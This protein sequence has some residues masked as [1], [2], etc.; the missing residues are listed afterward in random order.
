MKRNCLAVMIIALMVAAS[1][2]AAATPYNTVTVDGLW[3]AGEW[4]Q[5]NETVASNTFGG[6]GDYGNVQSVLVTWDAS[7][8]YVGLRG[9]AWNNAMLLYIDSSSIATGQ[10]N[11]DYFQGF[12]TQGFFDADFVA[13][14]YNMEWGSG[15]VP[16]DI[17]AISSV[18]GITT[19]LI[20]PASVAVHDKNGDG[21]LGEGLLEVAIP[22]SLIGLEVG[23]SVRVAA[24]VGWAINQNPVIPAGGLGGFSGDELGGT[25]QQGGTDALDSTLDGAV[26]VVYDADADGLPDQLTDALAPSLLSAAAL[27]GDNSLLAATFDEPVTQASAENLANWA[28][29]GGLSVTGATLQADPAV[30]HLQLDASAGFGQSYAVTATGIED[31]NSNVSGATSANF[32]LA[33]LTFIAHMKYKIEAAGAPAAVSLEG[34]MAPLTWDPTCDDPLY[35]DGTHGDVAAG[36]STYA[37]QLVFCLSY[38]EGETPPT[39]Q[40]A[41]KLTFGCTDWESISDRTFDLSCATGQD[42]VAFYWNNENPED[43]TTAPVDVI[44]TVDVSDS[45]GRALVGINGGQGNGSAVPPLNWNLPSENALSDDGYPG[46][47]LDD[48][49][50]GTILRFPEQSFRNVEYKFVYNDVYECQD[51]G[52]RGVWLNEAAFDTLGGVLGPLVMPTSRLQRCTVTARAVEV[53]FAVDMSY[54][55]EG[56]LPGDTLAVNGST[57][58]LN[59]DIPSLAAMADDGLYPDNAAGD[60]IFSRSVVFPDSSN[61]TVDY[62]YLWNSA[63]ECTTQGNRYF[64][65][66]D[67]LFDDTGNP[68]VLDV[69]IFNV[70]DA[71]AAEDTPLAAAGVVLRGNYPNP[72]NPKTDIVFTLAAPGRVRLEIFDLSGRLVRTL[73]DAEAPAGDHIARWAGRDDRGQAVSSGIYFARISAHGRFESRKMTLLK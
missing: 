42:T 55:A 54:L 69:D 15:T 72:F 20:G 30:V 33:E 16:T 14:C 50:Y 21:G 11:A 70:C 51:Q 32:C 5:A 31:L 62:K 61:F 67:T 22:W 53:V 56:P 49:I 25:D 29:D 19:S 45:L 6:W 43:F 60:L 47:V 26:T 27:E 1:L 38:G 28:I 64:W 39:V 52:N 48:G 18:D 2:P 34:S 63:Y 13:G 36:D 24:G 10:E 41:F 8:L 37:T 46:G 73:I 3:G 35:D 66:E 23:G 59:W 17:R 57:A 12:V 40:L 68:L 65:I 9:N 58:P 7:N 4:D 44:F 71:T